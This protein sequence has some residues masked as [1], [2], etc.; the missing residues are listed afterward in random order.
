[1]A[2]QL[3]GACILLLV[4]GCGSGSGGDSQQE[5]SYACQAA[6]IILSGFQGSCDTRTTGSPAGQCHEW[7]GTETTDVQ[8]ACADMGGVLDTATQCPSDGRVLRCYVG[9]S[10][11]RILHGYYA[12]SYSESEAAGECTAASGRCLRGPG[13]N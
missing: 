3:V 8:A 11:L 12:P 7:W 2:S 5:S 9:T 4:V 1:M 6:A 10:T 13:G